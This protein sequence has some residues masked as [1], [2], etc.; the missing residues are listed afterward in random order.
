M[1]LSLTPLEFR[2][3]L[4]PK[5]QELFDSLVSNMEEMGIDKST[6]EA[7][8]ASQLFKTIGAMK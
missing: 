8:V 6:A 2:D 7:V 4:A 3:M 5:L 1:K